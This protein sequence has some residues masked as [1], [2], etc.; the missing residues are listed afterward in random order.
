PEPEAEAPVERVSRGEQQRELHAPLAHRGEAALEEHA[1]DAAAAQLGPREDAADPTGRHD[2]AAHPYEARE[3]L[4]ARDEPP[5][6]VG[7]P[8]VVVREGRIAVDRPPEE[9]AAAPAVAHLPAVEQLEP[10]FAFVPTQG[11]DRESGHRAAILP[12]MSEARTLYK[13]GIDHFAHG[14]T[15]EAIEAHRQAIALD[16]KLALAGT[17]L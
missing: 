9:V 8:H 12:S 6:V 4:H 3:D 7:D 2:R 5:A 17:G 13:A 14:R 16:G 11:A 1:R 15:R 10:R